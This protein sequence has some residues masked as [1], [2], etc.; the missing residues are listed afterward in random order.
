MVICGLRGQAAGEFVRRRFRLAR[1]REWLA[2]DF[3]NQADDPGRLSRVQVNSP[4]EILE[5][6]GI[7]LQ[8]LR[9]P[10]FCTTACCERPSRRWAAARNRCYIASDFKTA[11]FA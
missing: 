7:E 6:L 11:D 2:L 5:R 10:G 3:T 9:M 1:P 4:S 8:G